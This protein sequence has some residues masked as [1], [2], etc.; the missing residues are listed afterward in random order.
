MKKTILAMMAL[1]MTLAFQSCL[2]DDTDL[3]D[4]KS[5]AERIEEAVDESKQLL[6]SA[7]NGWMMHFYYGQNYSGGGFTYLCKFSDGKAETSA[8]LF[9]PAYDVV[10]PSTVSRSSYNVIEDQGPVLTFDTHNE[11]IHYLAQAYQDDIDGDQ[12]DYEF[13]I[14]RTSQDSIYLKGKKWG[15]KVVMTRNKSDLNW[16]TYLENIHNVVNS[17]SYFYNITE[18]GEKVGKATLDAQSRH[19]VV[20]VGNDSIDRAF[21]MT[22]EGIH[23]QSAVKAG[24][25]VINDLKWNESDKSMTSEEAPGVV[26]T[27]YVPDF[28][29]TYKD[30]LS[31]FAGY[32]YLPASSGDSKIQMK[33]EM[34]SDLSEYRVSSSM[35]YKCKLS[36]SAKLSY[37]AYAEYD[38]TTGHLS[39]PM[40]RVLDPTGEYPVLMIVPCATKNGSSGEYYEFNTS[41][42]LDMQVNNETHD[43]V[44][45]WNGK[46]SKTVPVNSLIFLACDSSG[47]LITEDDY[48]VPVLIIKNFE[49]FEHLK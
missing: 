4:G 39:F 29:M 8:D 6:E 14:M 21:Y 2:H 46:G 17:M 23:F 49:N 12:G 37:D 36:L 45:V 33:F 20:V 32:A 10:S 31:S 1:G 40:Q 27:G 48:A 44:F 26:F 3:F 22:E 11:V 47:N 18:N 43:G 13:I 35:E 41:G 7:D 38:K 24:N 34:E 28:Y 5:P 25:F 30:W 16:Q 15:N 9:S 19:A 42:A